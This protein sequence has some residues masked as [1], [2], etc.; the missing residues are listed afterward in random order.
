MHKKLF[1]RNKTILSQNEGKRISE[2]LDCQ[3][4]K[5]SWRSMPPDPPV[6]WPRGPKKTM[7]MCTCTSVLRLKT[8]LQRLF[9]ILLR[10]LL[11]FSDEDN[12]LLALSHNPSLFI[13]LW[14]IKEPT[15]YMYCT[16]MYSQRAG[17]GVPGVVVCPL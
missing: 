7:C 5:R 17:H 16:C 3:K 2:P 8:T 14:D 10:T 6:A 4:K 15:H 13:T 11:V 9:K 1:G 12:Q